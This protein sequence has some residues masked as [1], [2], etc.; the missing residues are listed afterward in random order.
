M[1]EVTQLLNHAD[2]V[3]P[4]S[5]TDLAPLVYAELRKLAA[6]RLAREKPGQTLEPT[7]LVHEAYLRLLGDGVDKQWENRGHF[8]AA[9][10]IAMRR[11]LVER[12]RR[13]G[14]TKHG[15]GL[16]RVDLSESNCGVAE[17][18]AEEF[19]HLDEAL[20]RLA[21]EDP[22][23]AELA[24][25]RYFIGLTIPQAAEVLGVSPRKA[26]WIWS[27][28]RAWLRRELADN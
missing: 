21:A 13:Q 15:G 20:D 6:A 25:L 19:L 17:T 27:F 24:K 2:A 28:A 4:S 22:Q 1:I 5:A 26:D 8:F 10:A 23:A 11:I 3:D 7:A 9:A 18:T 16:R 14:R 12:A